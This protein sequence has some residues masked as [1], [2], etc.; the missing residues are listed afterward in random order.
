MIVQLYFCYLYF[1]REFVIL[2][3]QPRDDN[4][5]ECIITP[6]EDYRLMLELRQFGSQARENRYRGVTLGLTQK[7]FDSSEFVSII[8]NYND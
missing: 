4:H 6:C 3:F 7:P 5:T 2:L 1:S 8:Y